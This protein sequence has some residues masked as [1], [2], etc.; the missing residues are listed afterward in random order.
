MVCKVG[1]CAVPAQKSRKFICNA[2]KRN[3]YE[4]LNI[5]HITLIYKLRKDNV[6]S[7][8]AANH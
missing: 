2:L 4:E 5:Q 3:I 7:T 1:F 6:S 8:F